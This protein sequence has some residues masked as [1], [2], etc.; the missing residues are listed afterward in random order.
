VFT[1]AI[2][3]IYVNRTTNQPPMNSMVVGGYK[4]VD[5]VNPRGRYQKPSIINV[6]HFYYKAS[7][8][9]KPN[10]VVLKP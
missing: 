1:N 5:A 3:T 6:Q 4:N 2:T 10:K 7:H 9:V 8:Y